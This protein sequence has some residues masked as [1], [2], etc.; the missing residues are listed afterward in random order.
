MLPTMTNEE[1]N[2]ISL[3]DLL[4]RLEHESDL[5]TT[6]ENLKEFA[7]VQIQE[8]NINLAAHVLDALKQ[9]DGADYFRYDFSCG[10]L[11]TPEPITDKVD[12]VDLV[13]LTEEPELTT[14]EYN[15]A[16]LG[17]L[18]EK[19]GVEEDE[20]LTTLDAARDIYVLK[21]DK[22]YGE[23]APAL[24]DLEKRL[25]KEAQTH[26]ETGVLLPT[27]KCL[28]SEHGEMKEGEYYT[29]TEFD[30]KVQVLDAKVG[31]HNGYFKTAFL[32]QPPSDNLAVNAYEGR[33]D[34]GDND[35][36]I[37]KHM[38]ASLDWDEKIY[39]RYKDADNS[40]FDAKR[41]KELPEIH[42]QTR[43]YIGYIESCIKLESMC[44]ER[45]E[46]AREA[47][48]KALEKPKAKE[49]QIERN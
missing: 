4:D 15:A 41:R 40:P 1:F 31:E 8:G 43:A 24:N 2:D 21:S 5:V 34:I 37:V 17:R 26:S 19:F 28:W 48:D 47:A 45:N 23:V 39:E 14:E 29:L 38:R 27:V 16:F 20:R 10:T 12:I 33:Y 13:D 49:K 30:Q 9:D 46:V 3:E 36:G 42:A 32:I 6:R 22:D 18:E 25:Q 11:S 7:I 35:G 44:I